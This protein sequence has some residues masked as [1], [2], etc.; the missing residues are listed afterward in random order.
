[1]VAESVFA[2]LADTPVTLLVGARQS[3]K[4][5]LVQQI[6]GG[7]HP[8]TYRT[9]DDADTL[10]TPLMNTSARRRAMSHLCSVNAC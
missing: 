4:S 6:A 2:A 8:A 5:T 9:L 3:G 7:P 10:A 1:M